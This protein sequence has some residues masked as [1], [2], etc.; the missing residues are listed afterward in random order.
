M[1]IVRYSLIQFT[2]DRK[3]NETVNIGLLVFLQEE[4]SIHMCE[5]IRKI[6]AVDGITT[7]NELKIAEAR[8][9]K[10]FS[11]I[12]SCSDSFQR[13][14][15]FLR[16]MLPR[17]Y[18]LTSLGYFKCESTEQANL[19]IAKL[20]EDLVI[21]PKPRATRASGTRIITNLRKLF[22]QHNLFSTSVEDILNH[23]VVEKFPISER[24][25]LHADFA[26]K[27]GVYHI[28]ETIDLAARDSSMKF[29]EAGLKSFILA[30]AKLEL[31]NETRCYAVYSANSS[32]EKDKS[33]AIDLLNEGSDFIYN[34]NSAR[35]KIAYIQQMEDAA[36]VARLH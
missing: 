19:K 13:E 23:R 24:A 32:D 20:M 6:R 34:L 28:T 17:S 3:R 36:G 35:D 10:I 31:G 4:I 15:D 25:N 16:S 8:I 30:K 14:F 5:S 7:A 18:Q 27:N 9:R 21:P 2:P 1:N 11:S 12:D 29:K 26:M 33:E 22:Q